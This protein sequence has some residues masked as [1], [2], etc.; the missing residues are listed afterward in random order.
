MSAD[1]TA[2]IHLLDP[3]SGDILSQQDRPPAGYPTRDWRPEELVTDHFFVPWPEG[4]QPAAW[5]LR[6]GFYDPLT[7]QS[8]G[9]PLVLTPS[10]ETMR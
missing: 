7:L 1:Y 10:E 6:T 8:F 2:F 4:G 9:E 5:Q 3:G